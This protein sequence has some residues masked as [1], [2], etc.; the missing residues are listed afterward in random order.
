MCVCVHAKVYPVK[1]QTY[2]ISNYFV[3]FQAYMSLQYRNVNIFAFKKIIDTKV[4]FPI[5]M[6]SP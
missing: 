6:F 1:F 4:I 5:E 2:Y 3:K